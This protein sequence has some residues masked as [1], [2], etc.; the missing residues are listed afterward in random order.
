MTKGKGGISSIGPGPQAE[1]M[2]IITA[3]R[4]VKAFRVRNNSIDC[5]DLTDIDIS[6]S[7]MELIIHFLIKG[8]SLRC[9]NMAVKYARIAF[10]EIN[11]AL[12]EENIEAPSPPVSCAAAL[13]RKMGLSDMHATM[14]AGLAGGIGLCGGACGALGALIWIISMES[15]AKEDGEIEFKDSRA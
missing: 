11:T 14:V 13:A 4:L 6:S 10:N 15:G 3:Q 2:A 8:R 7:P 9:F 1:S 5:V 12:S